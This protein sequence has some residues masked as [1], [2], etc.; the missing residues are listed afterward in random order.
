MKNVLC[1]PLKKNQAKLRW[2]Q[3]HTSKFHGISHR[4]IWFGL[5]TSTNAGSFYWWNGYSKS[6]FRVPRISRKMGSNV[7]SNKR[8]LHFLPNLMF[9]STLWSLMLHFDKSSNMA[10]IWQKM[11]KNLAFNPFL[12]GT[13]GTRNP[14]FGYPFRQYELCS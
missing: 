12:H 5:G 13:A 2:L 3:L 7:K 10:K 11:K 9:F 4:I 1:R 6:D 14:G 8:F